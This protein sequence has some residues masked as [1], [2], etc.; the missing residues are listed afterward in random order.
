MNQLKIGDQE[1]RIKFLENSV[2][3]CQCQRDHSADVYF[4]GS[5]TL[6]NDLSEN[7][8]NRSTSDELTVLKAESGAVES[9]SKRNW[10]RL[11][12]TDGNIAFFAKLTHTETQPSTLHT[13]VFDSAPTNIGGHY[14]RYS[15]M[16]TAPRHGTYVFSW[17]MFCSEGAHISS[18]LI[19]NADYIDATLCNAEGATYIRSTTGVSVLEL[20]QGDVVFIRTH[21]T[22][23][24]RGDI[25]SNEYHL[26]T[27]SGWLL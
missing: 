3:N 5:R 10:R 16:F 25:K 6:N 21:P 15:G 13:F 9:A 24:H 26:S 20:N 22:S 11:S 14:N 4:D 1:K 18:Q 17:T 19:K 8:Q 7:I 27:F 23:G 12:G 2:E